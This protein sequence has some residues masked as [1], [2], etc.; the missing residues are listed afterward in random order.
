MHVLNF[1]WKFYLRYALSKKFVKMEIL[2]PFFSDQI[3][4]PQVCNFTFL[5][6]D[7][8]TYTCFENAEIT[9]RNWHKHRYFC[10]S[11]GIVVY[12]VTTWG[13]SLFRSI[14]INFIYWLHELFFFLKK[15]LNILEEF[16]D[17]RNRYVSFSVKSFSRKFSWKLGSQDSG[18]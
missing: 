8:Y 6:A 16:M 5:A 13:G 9:F 12:N 15:P 14:T 17:S 1:C 4:R 11:G 18:I 2:W 3:D 7:T 10:S